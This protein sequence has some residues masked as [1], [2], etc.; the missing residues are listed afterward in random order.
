MSNG[1]KRDQLADQIKVIVGNNTDAVGTDVR[2]AAYEIV[3]YVILPLFAGVEFGLRMVEPHVNAG[4]VAWM[5]DLEYAV[6][7]LR[8]SQHPE[9][10]EIVSRQVGHWEKLTN[11]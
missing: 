11:D 3:D 9:Q 10:L 5:P 2:S 1:D 4:E 7:Q 8:W 6:G